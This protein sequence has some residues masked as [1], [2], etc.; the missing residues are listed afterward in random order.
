MTAAGG[1]GGTATSPS[2]GECGAGKG[3]CGST[4]CCSAAGFCGTGSGELVDNLSLYYKILIYLKIFVKLPTANSTLGLH[5]TP[6][7]FQGAPIPLP[8]LEPKLETFSTA[9]LVFMIVRRKEIWLLHLMMG[10]LYTQA[11][12][13]IY[14]N[15]IMPVQ[16][17]SLPGTTTVCFHCHDQRSED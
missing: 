13:W 6:M 14:W 1:A 8:F 3:S 7:P 4:E 15:N 11:I 5:V 2:G 9:R 12:F 16:L 17:S 10:H